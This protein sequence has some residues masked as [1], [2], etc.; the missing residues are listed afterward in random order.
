MKAHLSSI[1]R[2]R[3]DTGSLPLS[4]G[5]EGTDRGGITSEGGERGLE[6]CLTL[7]SEAGSVVSRIHRK[8]DVSCF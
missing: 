3:R 1:A 6:E 8:R 7:P 4:E 2:K 5:G